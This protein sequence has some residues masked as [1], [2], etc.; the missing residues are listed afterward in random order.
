MWISHTSSIPELGFKINNVK[1]WLQVPLSS[2]LPS[3]SR[4]VIIYQS[5]VFKFRMQFLPF[6]YPGVFILLC[7]LSEELKALPVSLGRRNDA[8]HPRHPMFT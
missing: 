4:K 6:S 5:P 1:P 3:L 2:S 7:I 8:M